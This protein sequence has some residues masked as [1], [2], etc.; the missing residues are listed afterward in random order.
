MNAVTVLVAF[1]PLVAVSASKIVFLI[2]VGVCGIAF[3]TWLRLHL[4]DRKKK[5]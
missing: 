1:A 5:K 3:G 2:L 4:E